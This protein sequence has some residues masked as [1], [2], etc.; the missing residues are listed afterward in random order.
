MHS[1]LATA[2]FRCVVGA[3][4]M[5]VAASRPPSD[6]L[7]FGYANHTA[8]PRFAVLRPPSA[9]TLLTPSSSNP[10]NENTIGKKAKDMLIPHGKINWNEPLR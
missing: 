3:R 2:P 6:Q 9:S 4:A 5:Y 7:L 1:K 10:Y 8:T